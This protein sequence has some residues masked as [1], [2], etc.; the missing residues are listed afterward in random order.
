MIKDVFSKDKK[1][2][3]TFH[4]FAESDEDSSS[5]EVD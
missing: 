5:N 1:K 4:A 2:K 3:A